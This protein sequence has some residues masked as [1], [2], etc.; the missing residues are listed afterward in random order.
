MKEDM[1]MDTVISRPALNPASLKMA[2]IFAM[3]GMNM[4]VMTT[5]TT[6]CI[7]VSIP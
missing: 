3:H 5:A 7:A 1:L 4:V 2:T 6:L